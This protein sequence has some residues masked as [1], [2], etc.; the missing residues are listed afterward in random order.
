MEENQSQSS[1]SSSTSNSSGPNKFVLLFVILVIIVLLGAAA[2]FFL[3]GKSSEEP[4]MVAPTPTITQEV[5]PIPAT[6]SA[7]M[8]TESS[9]MEA[10]KEAAMKVSPTVKV[11]TATATV[12][13]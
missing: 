11:S 2:W 6:D 5:T 8:A 9:K 12:T 10:T 4:K 7:K 13:P 3:L 1:T